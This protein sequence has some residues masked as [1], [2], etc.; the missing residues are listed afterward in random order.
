[1]DPE[2]IEEITTTPDDPAKSADP[3]YNDILEGEDGTPEAD[4]EKG[5]D[6]DNQ[7]QEEKLFAELLI[8]DAKKL[9][10]KSKDE[11]ESFIER[12]KPLKDGF[13]RQ[14]DY[15]RKLQDIARVRKSYEAI[16]G[17]RP[18]PEELQALGRVVQDYGKDQ[19]WQE[20]INA[21][22]QGKNG[23]QILREMAGQVLANAGKQP[24]D[25]DIDPATAKILQ[26]LDALDERFKTQEE[27]DL[28][29][30]EMER[31]SSAKKTWESWLAK[32]K[33]TSADLEIS[34]EIDEAMG[35]V[36]PSLLKKYP[37]WGQDKILD[38]ALEIAETIND[39]DKAKRNAVNTAIKDADDA[40]KKKP[41]KTPPTTPQ[42]SVADM[43]YAD[44][45][46][47]S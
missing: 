19:V 46:M 21:K 16:F 1:M 11:F 45:F 13:L 15:T 9:P 18:Q 14:S 3:S 42:K 4:I 23:Q 5:E 22:I 25:A 20:I 10:F 39:P 32:K 34:E 33:E 43:S 2:D 7:S 8:D 12:N 27:K 6:A 30:A 36:I 37:E 40:K 41:L 31:L 24:D 17:Y 47:S 29:R 35:T 26:R 28:Q 44:I 38:R